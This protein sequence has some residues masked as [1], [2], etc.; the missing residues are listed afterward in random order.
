MFNLNRDAMKHIKEVRLL[1]LLAALGLLCVGIDRV[2]FDRIVGGDPLSTIQRI[3]TIVV[4][5]LLSTV[6][7]SL[8]VVAWR[9]RFPI[10]AMDT[11][12][13]TEKLL[14]HAFCG[15]PSA[16]VF[17]VFLVRTIKYLNILDFTVV[18]LFGASL[19]F[20]LF[21]TRRAVRRLATGEIANK[22]GRQFLW[23]CIFFSMLSCMLGMAVSGYVWFSTDFMR[24]FGVVFWS[25][26]TAVAIYPVRRD[27]R[28]LADAVASSHITSVQRD[29]D[30]K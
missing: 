10:T 13:I 17:G 21:W 23:S 12:S 3:L 24:S 18:V 25:A 29:Q 2:F 26:M 8:F 5:I 27:A 28:R 19:M 7:V 1:S 22:H 14:A 4:G 20:V 6:S 30:N 9:G 11:N 15:A 16:F